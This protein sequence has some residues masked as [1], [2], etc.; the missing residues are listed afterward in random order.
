MFVIA[1]CQIINIFLAWRIT[2]SFYSYLTVSSLIFFLILIGS[3]INESEKYNS[4][5]ASLYLII[6]NF[7]I[8]AG[9]F[10]YSLLTKNTLNKAMKYELAEAGSRISVNELDLKLITAAL[11]SFFLV[12]LYFFN[13]YGAPIFYDDL[14]YA[15]REVQDEA[16]IFY[17]FFQYFIP[18][19]T[20]VLYARY[21]IYNEKITK[22]ILIFCVFITLLILLGLGFKGYILWYLVFLLMV[23][24]VYQKNLLRLSIVGALL[25]ISAATTTAS[26]I[27][28]VSLSE[29][30][31]LVLIRST[32]IAAAGYDIVF[33]ELY[34]ELSNVNF[35]GRKLNLFLAEWKFGNNKMAQNSMGI[36]TTLPGAMMVYFGKV[37]GLISAPVTG[38]IMQSLYVSIF[39]YRLS[40]LLVVSYTYLTFS[41]VGVVAR[42][43]VITV[44]FQAILS[45]ILLFVFYLFSQ[46]FLSGS[47]KYRYTKINYPIK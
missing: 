23:A 39:K 11:L 7:L 32:S 29:A 43:T 21:R 28:S 46:A 31:K 13:T 41:F 3:L 15:R 45:L 4:H 25:S 36:T 33:Y 34:P 16:F 37:G 1:F 30:F 14:K 35:D 38:F 6:F 47:G 44:F 2:K 19:S 8:N 26:F 10:C 18:I 42:G 17:R 24:S 40:P 12:A 22:Y 5:E 27:F 9:A 20:A